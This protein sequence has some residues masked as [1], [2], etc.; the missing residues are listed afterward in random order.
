MAENLSEY[1]VKATVLLLTFSCQSRHEVFDQSNLQE[2]IDF[3]C[4]LW[5]IYKYLLLNALLLFVWI[6][7]N[8]KLVFFV[9]FCRVSR[10]NSSLEVCLHCLELIVV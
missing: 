9:N 3:L 6:G 2:L 7:K 10:A 5:Y 4:V 8:I 1:Q